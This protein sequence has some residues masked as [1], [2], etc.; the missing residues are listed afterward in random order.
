MAYIQ[1]EKVE[2]CHCYAHFEPGVFARK[3]ARRAIDNGAR[4]VNI[5]CQ[6]PFCGRTTWREMRIDRITERYYVVRNGFGKEARRA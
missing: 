2:C 1:I 3:K 5:E 4:I 6:C